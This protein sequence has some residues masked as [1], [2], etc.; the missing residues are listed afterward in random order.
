[1]AKDSTPPSRSPLWPGQSRGNVDPN[2]NVATRRIVKWRIGHRQRTGPRVATDVITSSPHPTVAARRTSSP[3][4]QPELPPG[5][6]VLPRAPAWQ[7]R[8][9]HSSPRRRRRP[10]DPNPAVVGLDEPGAPRPP[11]L[12]PSG[13]PGELRR[14]PSRSSISP[15]VERH[16]WSDLRLRRS[17][18]GRDQR[19]PCVPIT[20][21]NGSAGSPDCAWASTRGS[22][23]RPAA[24]LRALAEDGHLVD[25]V[26][27]PSTAPPHL[28]IDLRGDGAHDEEVRRPGHGR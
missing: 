6:H 22:R 16:G 14:Q 19:R 17:Q 20:T 10:A 23:S 27:R 25:S 3:A 21:G 9:A 15:P 12:Y 28:R 24:H 8:T 2:G 1:M 18:R 11:P 4:H 7:R 5:A 13:G 26:G